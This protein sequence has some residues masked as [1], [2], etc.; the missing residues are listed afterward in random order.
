MNDLTILNKFKKQTKMKKLSIINAI[1]NRKEL[2][3]QVKQEIQS[4]LKEQ[5][6]IN[7]LLATVSTSTIICTQHLSDKALAILEANEIE[8][9]TTV[10]NDQGF[11]CYNMTKKVKP[12]KPV[13]DFEEIEPELT[14]KSMTEQ[15][16]DHY[17]IIFKAVLKQIKESTSFSC[18]TNYIMTP[19]MILELERR[20]YK[21]EPA[22]LYNYEISWPESKFE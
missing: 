1:L 10:T 20:G 22:N 18:F 2:R 5:E 9:L 8:V 4:E 16:K 11:L 21:V 14:A 15:N 19:E 6:I 7:D 12:I 17:K 13:K 3:K